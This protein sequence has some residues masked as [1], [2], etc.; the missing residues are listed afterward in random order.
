MEQFQ[1][2]VRSQHE[3]LLKK[4]ARGWDVDE[5]VNVNIDKCGHQELT[6]KPVHDSSMPRD[7]VTKILDLECA[8]ESR[9]KESSKWSNDGGKER[10]EEAVD[11]ERVEGDCF[12]HSQDPPP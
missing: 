11:E 6:V 8:L 9:S 10:H 7:Q 4:L 1:L 12:F 5:A 3:N 2:F